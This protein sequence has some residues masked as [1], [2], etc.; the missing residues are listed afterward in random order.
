MGFG[1]IIGGG[2]L[3]LISDL[4]FGK[5]GGSIFFGSC[6]GEFSVDGC[7]SLFSNHFL[8]ARMSLV[9]LSSL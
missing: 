9:G 2:E 8:P 7:G 6:S 5:I 3:G 1:S 4:G